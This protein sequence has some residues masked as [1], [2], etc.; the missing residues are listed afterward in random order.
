MHKYS[1]HKSEELEAIVIKKQNKLISIVALE[2]DDS[3]AKGRRF[4]LPAAIGLVLF[5]NQCNVNNQNPFS[6]EFRYQE[7]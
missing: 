4:E 7:M 2:E 6:C 3:H 5:S 1:C